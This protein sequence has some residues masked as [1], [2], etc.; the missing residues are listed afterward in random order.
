V[1][2]NTS[3]VSKKK[4]KKKKIKKKKKRKKREERKK[5]EKHNAFGGKDDTNLLTEQDQNNVKETLTLRQ[6]FLI[7]VFPIFFSIQGNHIQLNFC[8][9]YFKI[10]GT[11]IWFPS[12]CSIS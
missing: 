2:V 11:S 4:K 12:I 9:P 5:K 7:C 3:Q 6:S 8:H 10:G 1:T